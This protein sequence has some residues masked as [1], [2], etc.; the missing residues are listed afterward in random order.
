MKKPQFH[1]ST[2]SILNKN[3]LSFS[4]IWIRSLFKMKRLS[5]QPNFNFRAIKERIKHCPKPSRLFLSQRPKKRYQR[6]KY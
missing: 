5:T 6:N 1:P 4:W 2:N 3:R